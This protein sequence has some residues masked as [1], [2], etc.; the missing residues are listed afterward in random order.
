MS[1]SFF[2]PPLPPLEF[3]SPSPSSSA[4][5]GP[6]PALIA[7]ALIIFASSVF[8]KQFQCILLGRDLL[9]AGVSGLL[10]LEFGDSDVDNG[11]E[12]GVDP[13]EDNQLVLGVRLTDVSLARGVVDRDWRYRAASDALRDGR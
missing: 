10:A 4:P 13:A 12:H 5:N 1:D 2:E 7:T 9:C 3:L 8:F 6:T 11:M